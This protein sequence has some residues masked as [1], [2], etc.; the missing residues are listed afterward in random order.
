MIT[1][2]AE[3]PSVARAISRVLGATKK[4]EGYLS[5]NGYNVA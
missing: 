3:K 1:V 2:I 4:E 5:G